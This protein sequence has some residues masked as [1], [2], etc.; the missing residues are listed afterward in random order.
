MKLVAVFLA[1]VAFGVGGT[2]GAQAA[3]DEARCDPTINPYTT[4]PVLRDLQREP[5]RP[6]PY[7]PSAEDILRQLGER[8]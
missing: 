8:P 7:P 2:F 6:R 4:N 5:C 1:G 3:T